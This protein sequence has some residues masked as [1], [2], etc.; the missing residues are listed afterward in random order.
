MQ[1]SELENKTVA[2]LYQIAREMNIPGY[3]RLRKRE[4]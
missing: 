4:L 2:E 3:Y 1:A